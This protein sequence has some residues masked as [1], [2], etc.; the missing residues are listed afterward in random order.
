MTNYARNEKVTDEHDDK[1][2]RL[3]HVLQSHGFRSLYQSVTC[4]RTILDWTDEQL[5]QRIGTVRE[6]LTRNIDV[7]DKW[8][9]AM[10]AAWEVGDDK[11]AEFVRVRTQPGWRALM[12]ADGMV[13]DEE[14]QCWVESR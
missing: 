5:V 12:E 7:A 10:M 9:Q 1:R 2:Q 13:W 4:E 8:F 11:L 14:S 3:Y 6:I